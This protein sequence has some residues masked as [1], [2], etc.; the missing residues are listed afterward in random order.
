MA[1]YRRNLQSGGIFFFTVVLYDRRKSFLTHY[2]SE[3]KKSYNAEKNRRPFKTIAYV[4]LPEHCHI[5]WELPQG[6]V[7]YSGR[8][9]EIKKGFTRRLISRGI[10]LHKNKHCEY[11]VWQR[12]FWE[13]T[14][15]DEEDLERHVDYIYYNPVKHGLVKR[16]CDWR[17]SSFHAFAVNGALPMN[18]A[19]YKANDLLQSGE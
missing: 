8:W 11:D 14:I 12:G 15:K 10:N 1:R 5:I 4:I 18:W 13:H 3:L 6:D 7:D 9:R 17:Y 2:H 19:G 16:V